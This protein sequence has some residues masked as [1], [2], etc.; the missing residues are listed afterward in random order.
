EIRTITNELFDSPEG[1]TKARLKD[2]ADNLIRK[3]GW[4]AVYPAWKEYLFTCDTPDKVYDYALRYIY[5]DGLE[6]K[7]RDPYDFLGYVMY[8][9]GPDNPYRKGDAF[10]DLGI[11]MVSKSGRR[12]AAGRYNPYYKPTKDPMVLA[13]VRMYRQELG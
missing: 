3:Y 4:D 5:Y 8:R 10:L 12:E 9:L 11:E 13:W 1:E 6:H 2:K 7:V